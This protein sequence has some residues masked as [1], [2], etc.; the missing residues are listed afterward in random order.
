MRGNVETS[1]NKKLRYLN[2]KKKSTTNNNNNS[3]DTDD[4]NNNVRISCDFASTMCTSRAD[5]LATCARTPHL[6]RC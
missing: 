5:M 3:N 4:N 2:V 1:K 6:I